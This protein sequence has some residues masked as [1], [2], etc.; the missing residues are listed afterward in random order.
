[1]D[2]FNTFMHKKARFGWGDA[3]EGIGEGLGSIGPYLVGVPLV[4][5]AAFGYLA[6][7]MSSPTD[8]DKEALQERV[9]DATV[10]EQLALR[11]RQ[12]QAL[13]RKLIERKK[14]QQGAA[15]GRDMF[16]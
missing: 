10:R 5:G 12:M 6:S 11:Q 3:I 9:I 1:M 4:G 13:K 16:V 7:K 15:R 2:K 14:Q 8:S